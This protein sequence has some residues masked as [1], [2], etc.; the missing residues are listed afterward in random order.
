MKKTLLQKFQQ[1]MAYFISKHICL[2]AKTKW[3]G[4]FLLSLLVL[5]ACSKEEELPFS[6][7]PEIK[8]LG[9]SHDTIVEY[10]DVLIISIQYKDGDGDLGFE[11]PDQYSIFVR[12]AR[13]ENFDGFYL[14]P[15]APPGVEVP[16]QGK[17][18]IEFPSLFLFGNRDSESTR[19][20]IKVVDRAGNESNL[21]ETQ[22]ILIVRSN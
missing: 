18:D 17:L 13:L 4:L 19:F 10:E 21:L 3:V 9:V 5:T 11:D 6:R 15:I 2:S 14:G 8:L 12:D 22:T 1:N 7:V 16:I 20:F